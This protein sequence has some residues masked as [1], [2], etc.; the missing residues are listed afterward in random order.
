MSEIP[1][2]IRAKAWDLVHDTCLDTEPCHSQDGCGCFKAFARA[3]MDERYR[4]MQIVRDELARLS[5]PK[6]G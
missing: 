5:H 3:I 4:C 1:E 2:D 6:R